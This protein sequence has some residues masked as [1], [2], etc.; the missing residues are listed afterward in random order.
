MKKMLGTVLKLYQS[1]GEFQR[2][3]QQQEYFCLPHLEMILTA[4]KEKLNR[5]AFSDFSKVTIGMTDRYLKQVN[6]DVSHFCKMYDYRNANGDWGNSRDS[7]ER[8]ILL[9]ASRDYRVKSDN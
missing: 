3:Y 8:A 6:D 7:I 1:D 9:L 5:S 4:A 2:L